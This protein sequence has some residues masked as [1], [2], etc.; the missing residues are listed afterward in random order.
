MLSMLRL[1]S[2]IALLN[3]SLFA[4]NVGSDVVDILKERFSANSKIEQ[5]SIELKDTVPVPDLKGWYAVIINVKAVVKKNKAHI[6]QRMTWF[7]NGTV[8][9]PDFIDLVTGDSVKTTIQP[10]FNEKFYKKEYLVSGSEHSKHKIAI[11]SDPLCP[12]C[13][14]Y[15]PTALKYMKAHPKKFAVYFYHLPLKH[16]HPSSPILVKAS[17]YAELMGKKDVV[18]KLYSLNADY[19]ISK[20]DALKEFNK[21]L[22][23]NITKKDLNSPEVLKIYKESEKISD[24]MMVRGTPTVFFDGKVDKTK[25]KYE[26]AK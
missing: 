6:S 13:K 17:I 23:M 11:F 10:K 20:K 15:V 25:K 19:K 4:S 16:I 5:V 7:S 12:F 22:K 3:I 1:L 18:S 26:K 24:E 2:I 21:V 14:R 8:L 9:A